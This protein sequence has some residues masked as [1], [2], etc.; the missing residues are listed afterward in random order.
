LSKVYYLTSFLKITL[1]LKLAN[2]KRIGPRENILNQPDTLV[3]VAKAL[4]NPVFVN[5]GDFHKP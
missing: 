1:K 5:I 3:P 4:V 2:G